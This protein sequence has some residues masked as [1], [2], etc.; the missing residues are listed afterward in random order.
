AVAEAIDE[1]A[2]GEDADDAP[3]V[4]DRQRQADLIRAR[5]ERR[6]EQR[7]DILVE[8]ER[9]PEQQRAKRE[10]AMVPAQPRQPQAP[11]PA[12]APRS[13]R[14]GTIA[15]PALPPFATTHSLLVERTIGATRYFHHRGT[16]DTET[17]GPRR[18]RKRAKNTKTSCCGQG[19]FAYFFAFR[20]SRVPKLC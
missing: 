19:P 20:A 11:K 12:P 6:D 3:A 7:Q 4:A 1:D 13:R 14:L 9:R 18:S 5:A 8:P 16:E 15:G 10:E 17:F 2:A